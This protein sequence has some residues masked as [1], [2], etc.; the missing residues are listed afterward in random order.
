MDFLVEPGW[1]VIKISVVIVIHLMQT[2][3]RVRFQ[4]LKEANV[5]SNIYAGAWL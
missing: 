5:R 1:Y 3:I 2:H 4:V